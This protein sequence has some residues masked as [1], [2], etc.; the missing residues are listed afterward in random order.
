MCEAFNQSG[1]GGCEGARY[2]LVVRDKHTRVHIPVTVERARASARPHEKDRVGG[3]AKVERKSA[4]GKREEGDRVKEEDRVRDNQSSVN[5]MHANHT[6]IPPVRMHT[7]V[8][9]D[10]QYME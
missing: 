6:N 3:R 10:H 2:L 8:Q 1:L 7:D 4:D 5:K 9:A